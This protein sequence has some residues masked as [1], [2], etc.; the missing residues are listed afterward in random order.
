MRS[1]RMHDR[2]ASSRPPSFRNTLAVIS[3]DAWRRAL[4]H[5]PTEAKTTRSLFHCAP[6]AAS[7]IAQPVSGGCTST[8]KLNRFRAPLSLVSGNGVL[9][10]PSTVTFTLSSPLSAVVNVSTT[11]VTDERVG[12]FQVALSGSAAREF[13]VAGPTFYVYIEKPKILQFEILGE[14]VCQ[15]KQ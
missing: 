5:S 9:F 1:S 4:V 7:L 2:M 11:V 12:P 8:I 13:E 14:V 6:S 3:L 10:A 15:D